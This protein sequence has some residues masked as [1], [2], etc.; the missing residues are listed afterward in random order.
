MKENAYD[1]ETFFAQYSQFPRSVEGLQAAGEWHALQKM[2]PDFQGKRVL[3]LGCGFGWHCVYAA[4]HGAETVL[5]L[6]C[7]EKMLTEARRKTSDPRIRYER[8]AMED[9]TPVPGSFDVVL[10][11]LAFHYV[12]DFKEVCQKIYTALAEGGDFVF[13][14]EHPVF[15]A[16][17]TQDWYCDQAGEIL[18]WPVDRYFE[19][20]RRVAHFL[21]SDV[22]KYHKTLTTYVN[23]LLEIGFT[24][25]GL[26]EPEPDPRLLDSVPGM[27]D[28]LRRPMMLLVSA[29]KRSK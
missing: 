20:G 14:C 3:D 19:E 25:T 10:S 12:E 4:E 24:L 26:V 17:G 6:D 22:V 1:D 7:S 8:T 28:E 15:T 29:Q 13:S 16:Y 27:R 23:T 21:G 9:F 11:S 18:H 2:L 5:G